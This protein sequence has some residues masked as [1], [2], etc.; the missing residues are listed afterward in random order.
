MTISFINNDQLVP[1]SAR[2]TRKVKASAL[3][4][5]AVLG[6]REAGAFAHVMSHALGKLEQQSESQ[7]PGAP[8]TKQ[9]VTALLLKMQ[10]R[11]ND[12]LFQIL[13]NNKE[14]DDTSLPFYGRAFSGAAVEEKDPSEIPQLIQKNDALPPPRQEVEEIINEAAGTYGV[15]AALIR[16]VIRA[17]SGFQIRSTSPR[18]AQGLMQLMPDTARE[19]GVKDSYDP[20][21][22]IMGGVRYLRMLLDRYHGDESLA[23]AAYNWG[24]G[25]L[26]R[27][28]DRLPKETRAYVSRVTEYWR[29]AKA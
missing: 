19:L 6:G 10:R 12:R 5:D 16:S 25:N 11:V 14:N 22:N 4:A 29:T 24:M 15:D 9:D 13:A 2:A 21:Q 26:E 7:L 23:L 8:L 20:R 27:S 17:E 3:A 1:P 28:P 18:G